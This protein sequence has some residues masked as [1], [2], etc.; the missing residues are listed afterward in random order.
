MLS[1]LYLFTVPRGR[2]LRRIRTRLSLVADLTFS[3]G[4]MLAWFYHSD[5]TKIKLYYVN[6]FKV[7]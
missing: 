2:W 5:Y 4:L 7:V 6:L 3:L 1:D